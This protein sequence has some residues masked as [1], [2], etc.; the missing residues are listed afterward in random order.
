M[1]NIGPLNKTGPQGLKG[2]D[3]KDGA[4]IIVESVE[5]GSGVGKDGDLFLNSITGDVFKRRNGKWVLVGNLIGPKGAKGP[6]GEQ[7]EKGKDGKNGRSGSSGNS[8]SDSVKGEI[9]TVYGET[10]VETTNTEVLATYTVPAG[11][12]FE[13]I[14]VLIS[15]PNVADYFVK[16]NGTKIHTARTYWGEF[17]EQIPFNRR[18]F[19][20]GAVITVECYNFRPT[21]ETFNATLIGDLYSAG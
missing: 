8:G 13:L 10:L 14:E 16:E 17:D 21:D 19:D 3:G 7:G 6:K 9:K 11:R 2:L 20:A 5:P 15:G 12:A 4:D 1:V 18:R